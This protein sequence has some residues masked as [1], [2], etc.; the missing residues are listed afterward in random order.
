[1]VEPH[2]SNFRVITTNFLGVSEYLG[3]LRYVT[4]TAM[5]VPRVM[6][7]AYS[8]HIRIWVEFKI[9]GCTQLQFC[10][11]QN[12]EWFIPNKTNITVK[13]VFQMPRLGKRCLWFQWKQSFP[14]YF[15]IRHPL[16]GEQTS[17]VSFTRVEES[18]R[19]K[20]AAISWDYETFHPP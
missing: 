15:V 9:V 11:Y 16:N 3:S 6:L 14:N 18:T 1:M 5:R 17:P 8:A 19:L 2:S 12:E 20:W 10:L 7:S 4:N 13:A